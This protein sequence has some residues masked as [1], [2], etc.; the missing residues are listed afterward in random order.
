[1]QSRCPYGPAAVEDAPKGD[2]ARCRRGNT[3]DGASLFVLS[4]SRASSAGIDPPTAGAVLGPRVNRKNAPNPSSRGRGDAPDP[5]PGPDRVAAQ[6]ARCHHSHRR[7]DVTLQLPTGSHQPERPRRSLPQPRLRSGRLCGSARGDSLGFT[8]STSWAPCRRVRVG[9]F[10]C[11]TRTGP[12][13]GCR[14]FTPLRYL[15][16]E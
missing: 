1:M 13:R 15:V 7:P 2:S 11:I 4:P 6:R 10:T 8:V 3:G 16:H 14:R 9:Y 12:A 5:D